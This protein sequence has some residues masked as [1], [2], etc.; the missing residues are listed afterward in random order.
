MDGGTHEGRDDGIGKEGREFTMR[1]RTWQRMM[2]GG[3]CL[4]LG[5]LLAAVQIEIRVDQPG[6]PIAPT[7]WGVF[8]E[9][10]NYGA[11][12]GLYPERIKNR[13]FD[14]PDP[15]M[16]WSVVRLEGSEGDVVTAAE[17]PA[18]TVRPRYVRVRST[19]PRGGL[20]VQN[21]GFFGIAVQAGAEFDCSVRARSRDERPPVLRVELVAPDGTLLDSRV[22][23][24]VRAEWGE[25]SCRLLPKARELKARV[26]VTFGSKADEIESELGAATAVLERAAEL[27]AVQGG[28]ASY[29]VVG[30]MSALEREAGAASPAPSKA[31]LASQEKAPARPP[32]GGRRPPPSKA[33]AAPP[34][35]PP[36]KPAGKPSSDF[37]P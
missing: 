6:A 16:G 28:R 22:L 11:D 33:P 37:D 20:G 27:S 21:E 12:G 34:A 2:I 5:T 17:D 24:G 1:L 19:S 35:A 31:A 3:V 26:Q 18:Q 7:M 10:I 8:F 36:P 4:G 30:M 25:L 23:R 15:L 29:F 13:S 32:S 9:D 14:F